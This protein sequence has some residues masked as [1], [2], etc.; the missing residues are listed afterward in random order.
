M[1][2]QKQ[3]K[4]ISRIIRQTIKW[5]VLGLFTLL[6]ILAL[7]VQ[8]SWKIITLF[9][10]VLLACTTMPRR[11]RKWIWL[12]GAAVLI[13]LVAWVFLPDGNDIWQPYTFDEELAG[14]EAK[15]AVAEEEN[16]AIIYNRL[17]RYF[18]SEEMNLKFLRP[19]V[20]EMALSEPWLSQDHPKLT[21]WLDKHED[22]VNTLQQIQNIKRCRLPSIIKLTLT[23]ELEINRYPSLKSWAVLLLLSGNNDIAEDRLDQALSKYACVLQM[24]DHLYQQKRMVDFLMGFGIE[25]LA[26]PPTGRFVIEHR[27]SQEQLQVVSDALTSL[28]N[29][30]SSDFSECLE[31]DKL[32]VK[33]AFCSLF[34]QINPGGRVRLSRDPAAAMWPRLRPGELEETY[35]QRKSMKACTIPAWFFLPATP[36][37]AAEMIDAVYEKHCAKARLDFDWAR[38]NTGPR[39]SLKLNC[40]SVVTSLTNRS[41]RLYGGFHDIY[42]KRL[43]QRRGLRVLIAIQQYN[44][45]NGCWPASLDAIKSG[46]PAEAFCDPVSKS[47]LKYENHGE[48]FSL[49]GDTANVW[50]K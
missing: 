31:Y 3:E 8:A 42:M 20:R 6:L 43:A 47:Q 21:R 7:I 12:L 50:P 16:A 37:K 48:R 49:Y 15:Y 40:R 4:K 30:W 26:F 27:F 23:D 5:I 34:Y 19:G 24:A 46:A 25:C 18:D 2:E 14:H 1:T 39:P 9:A 45:E 33:G 17:L 29:N 41:T 32:F 44:I 10:I 38:E 35:W 13:S 28:E 22:T 11:L 36:E